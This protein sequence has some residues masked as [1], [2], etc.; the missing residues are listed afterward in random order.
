M[1][2]KGRQDFML[3]ILA[4]ANLALILALS[5]ALFSVNGTLGD[6]IAK[7]ESTSDQAQLER[8]RNE[9]SRSKNE[10]K[11]ADALADL[12]LIKERIGVTSTESKHARDIAQSVKRQQDKT[13]KELA[14][15][16]N[17]SDVDT[18]RKDATNKIAELQQD[19]DTKFG[20]VSGELTGVKR[21]LVAARDDFGR[22]NERIATNSAELADLRK[23]GDRD[24]FEFDIRKSSRQQFQRVA[25]IQLSV[26][27][28]DPKNHR[29]NVAIQVDDSRIEKKDRT[30]NEP[31]QFLVGRDQLRYELVVNSVDKDRLRGYLSAPKDKAIAGEA[32][33]FRTP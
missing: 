25:D 8:E 32:P 10:A 9:D 2:V 11:I 13:A 12:E 7:V 18:L 23:K 30:T 17:S 3:K 19:S 6:R 28:T 33:R 16:A 4:G 14:T 22:L 15:K 27:K 1:L 31:I 24:Y 26:L 5:Y 21:D 20:N 29:Y